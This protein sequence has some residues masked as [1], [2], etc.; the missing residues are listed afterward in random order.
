MDSDVAGGRRASA[1]KRVQADLSSAAPALSNKR[2]KKL[3]DPLAGWVMQ[4]PNTGEKLTGHEWVKRYPKEFAGRYKK[5][6]RR[7]IE[8][9]AQAEVD[10]VDYIFV[11]C[12]RVC[13]AIACTITPSMY[14]VSESLS[15]GSLIRT[16]G[17]D[18]IYSLQ[19]FG[20]SARLNTLTIFGEMPQLPRLRVSPE[21][22]KR[23]VTH[24]RSGE[25]RRVRTPNLKISQPED[26]FIAELLEH[27]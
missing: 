11:D 4:D 5:G 21:W 26:I 1:R 9:L 8:Y 22:R 3:E 15:N 6:H 25:S 10:F 2:Q 17:N 19:L 14:D 24:W 13:T 16:R 23:T 7:C 12:I 20:V 18:K 27:T